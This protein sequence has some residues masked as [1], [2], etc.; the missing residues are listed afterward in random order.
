MEIHIYIYIYFSK[1]NPHQCH[2]FYCGSYSSASYSAKPQGQGGRRSLA[3]RAHCWDHAH[4]LTSGS[5]ESTEGK[6]SP[7]AQGSSLWMLGSPLSSSAFAST[8]WPSQGPLPTVPLCSC[9][10][11]GHVCLCH[12][13]K[14]CTRQAKGVPAQEIFVQQFHIWTEKLLQIFTASLALCRLLLFL[15]RNIPYPF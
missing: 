3:L 8:S 6:D 13:Q 11:A 5:L 9:L 10:P 12:Q 2:L 4:M 15:T 7:P 1:I 14:K